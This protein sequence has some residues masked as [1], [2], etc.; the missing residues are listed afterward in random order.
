MCDRKGGYSGANKADTVVAG[1]GDPR[2]SEGRLTACLQACLHEAFL[3]RELPVPEQVTNIRWDNI[4][5][6]SPVHMAAEVLRGNAPEHLL[7]TLWWHLCRFIEI[8]QKDSEVRQKV[9]FASHTT[10]GA[11]SESDLSKERQVIDTDH[12]MV[13]H[14]FSDRWE[15][16]RPDERCPMLF[17]VV[18][19]M[20]GE[21][22]DTRAGVYEVVTLREF[23]ERTQD[24]EAFHASI[25]E[26][27]AA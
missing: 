16:E 2:G 22:G 9:V 12:E 5:G 8:H 24:I 25:P 21:A 17:D 18:Y 26:L 15:A 4:S 20:H 1:C 23:M 10:C 3:Q 14:W 11:I 27:A 19:L 6:V 13:S 7:E